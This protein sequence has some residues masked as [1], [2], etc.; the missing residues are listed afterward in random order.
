MDSRL[1][2][3][4]AGLPDLLTA[5]RDY[6]AGILDDLGERP[7]A[8]TRAEFAPQPLPVAGVGAARALQV[9]RERWAPGFSGSAGPRYLGF[10]TGGATPA[11]LVGDW[12]TGAFDQNAVTRQD[13]SAVDLER[14]TVGWLRSLFGLGAGHH[15]TFVSGATM[16]NTVGLAIGREWLGAQQ[17]ISVARQGVAALG[18][19][20][21]LSGAPH[22]SIYK[23][24]SMLGIGRDQ[25]RTVP[26]LDDREAVDVAALEAALAAIDG[27]AIVVANA[28]TVNTVDFDDLSAISRLK[29]KYPFWLHV[30]A[31]FGGF[32]A[33]SEDHKHLVA[34][35]DQAD[36]IC[37]DLHKWLNVP[38]DAAIQFTRRRDLQLNVFQN[39]A[40]YLTPPEGDPDLF[41]L[42]PENSRRLRALTAWFT[43]AAYG[44]EGHREVVERNVAAA[45]RFGE[46]VAGLPGV[47]V[48]APVRLNVVCFA[49]DDVP[50]VL[51]AVAR[52][53]EAFLTPTVHRG[54]PALR[55]AFANWRTGEADA[56]R[57]IAALAKALADG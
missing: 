41:H 16:S 51:A 43:L 44:A 56:D 31:A 50:A 33:L 11:A 17:G 1:A 36:S 47:R 27:P 5:A 42:T 49:V 21:V 30:D 40:A 52:S 57:V 34:G 25:L 53:G 24:L 37:I 35:L 12:L 45:R 9:F 8:A 10:V 48:L 32:A 19:I 20:S 54:V 46:Q 29:S 6:A 26:L 13:S 23:A 38:Y 22:S 7:V 28:G 55:A 18:D 15:G 3:D 4:L 14:E 2:A 39:A